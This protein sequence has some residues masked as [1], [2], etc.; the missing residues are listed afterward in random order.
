MLFFKR[1]ISHLLMPLFA[2]NLAGL[3]IA[4][5][6]LVSEGQMQV[7]WLGFV[8]L[9]LSPLIIPI[10]LVPAGVFSHYMTHYSAAG[11]PDKERLM[12]VLSLA[13]IILFLTFWCMGIFEYVME[14][15]SSRALAPGLL[16]SSSAAIAPLLWWSRRDRNNFFIMM[17][18]ETA[19]LAMIALSVVWLLKG[20]GSFWLASGILGGI[21]LFVAVL[22]S[23][24]E[25]KFMEKPDG[26]PH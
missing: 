14:S 16:W 19:Q 26:A 12:F 5:L 13:Y 2:L 18:V 1:I 7:I 4:A 15:V 6:W 22:Q 25:K 11:R 8:M 17:L 10:L 23:V 3:G 20:A 9:F 21:L 24:Y